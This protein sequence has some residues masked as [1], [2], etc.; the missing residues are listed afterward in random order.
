MLS[1]EDPGSQEPPRSQIV[2]TGIGIY[3]L[4]FSRRE[5]KTSKLAIMTLLGQETVTKQQ[6]EISLC[7][8]YTLM[9]SYVHFNRFIDPTKNLR[10]N[11]ASGRLF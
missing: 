7:G 9:A 11:L 4:L 8:M 6:R 1:Q 3:G 10:T 5:T 2:R